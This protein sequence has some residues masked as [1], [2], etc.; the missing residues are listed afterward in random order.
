MF[1]GDS[2]FPRDEEASRRMCID[3][4]VK[5]V[6]FS[7][8]W[9]INNFSFCRE[10]MGEVLKS[11]TFSAGS[12]DKL[13]WCLRVNPKGLDEESKDYLSLYLL[14]V[15]CNKSEVRAKFKFSILNAKRE[16][17][18]AME[19]Q[20][21]YRFVQGKDWGFKKFIRRDFLFDEAN[22]LLPDD[23]LTLYCEVSVVADSVNISGQSN[24]SPFRVPDCRLADDLGMLFESQ[25]FS[26]VTLAAAEK[27]FVAHKAILAARSPVFAAMFEHE[28]E[29]RK[30]GRV[31]IADV[32]PEVLQEMLRFVYTGKSPNLDKLAD[33][34]LAAADK[35]A[36]ER[37]KIMCEEA[38]SQSLSIENAADVLILADLHSADQLKSQAIEFINTHATDVMETKGWKSMI[39]RHPHLIAEAFRALATQQV[40]PIGPPRKRIKQT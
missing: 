29:E 36:L 23:K 35:Y 11:S 7:Y 34:L 15:S 12:N 10:E 33:E 13:K 32:E 2:G 31:E 6:K 26:D 24:A 17:T 16:E 5:V 4:D 40:P 22:G 20:R 37:L 38:L 21:A 28:M 18:K 25:R 1:E 9:T 19:S 14:L 39:G 27:E 8:M 30:A 3:D